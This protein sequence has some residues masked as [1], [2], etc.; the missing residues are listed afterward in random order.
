M[1]LYKFRSLSHLEW[2]ADILVSERLYCPWYY[3][4]NDPFE[5][6]CTERGYFGTSENPGRRYTTATTIDDLA[7]PA[8]PT[9]Y[10]VC[11]LSSSW[12]DVRMWSHYGDGHR[13]VAIEIDFSEVEIPP[14]RVTYL[15]GLKEYDHLLDERP[16]IGNILLKKTKHWS[17]EDEYRILTTERYYSIKGRIRRILL[18][19]R[20]PKKSLNV[21]QRLCPSGASVESTRLDIDSV[22]TKLCNIIAEQTV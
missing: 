7:D 16:S 10:R 18:G 3:D 5:G 1:N 19:P 21:I 12:S 11:S 17:Y 6:I 22:T 20:F 4:L 2:L 14:R 9:E 15:D 13:G 8:N